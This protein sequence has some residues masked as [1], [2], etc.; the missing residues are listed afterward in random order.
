MEDNLK[1]KPEDEIE[2]N[3]ATKKTKSEPREKRLHIQSLNLIEDCVILIN[4]T[5]E[6]IDLS[7]YKVKSSVGSQE[8]ALTGELKA[9][10]CLNIWS[11]AKNN[12]KKTAESCV[13]WT[14]KYIWNDKGDT[15]ILV[16]SE[17]TVVDEV[18]VKG[19][20]E[21]KPVIIH[22]LDL[23]ADYVIVLNQGQE[24]ADISEWTLASL[25]GNQRFVFPSETK[26]APGQS[27]TVWSGTGADAK[28]HP[29]S[30]FGWTKKFIWNNKADSAALY[31]K[32]GNIVDHKIESGVVIP[33]VL[34]K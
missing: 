8:L 9:G 30:T 25:T 2:A 7:K 24:E 14:S 20:P 29:P 33:A 28:N 32:S 22:T 26:L 3:H 12:N 5:E 31:D 6:N 17:G 34:K 27:T 19:K 11:G 16:D 21:R 1:R 13:F 23:I 15:A 10:A 4:P 18:Q